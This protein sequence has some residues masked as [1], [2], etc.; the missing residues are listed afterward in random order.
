MR[1]TDLD[2]WQHVTISDENL[3]A[4]DEEGSLLQHPNVVHVDNQDSEADDQNVVDTIL[5]LNHDGG[6]AGPALLQNG[7]APEELVEGVIPQDTSTSVGAATAVD[8]DV[9]LEKAV[10]LIQH[11]LHSRPNNFNTNPNEDRPV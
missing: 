11:N 2:C 7:E 8:A 3:L 6:D 1:A 4:W 10:D 9:Q 5:R